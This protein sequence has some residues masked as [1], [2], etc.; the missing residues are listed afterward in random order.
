MKNWKGTE[1]QRKKEQSHTYQEVGILFILKETKNTTRYVQILHA[2]SLK[3]RKFA[4]IKF[5]LLRKKLVLSVFQGFKSSR[6][7][8]SK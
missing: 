6:P 8:E 2:H 1:N 4:S 7:I 3:L 5:S